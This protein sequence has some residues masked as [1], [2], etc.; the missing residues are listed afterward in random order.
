MA[1]QV[2]A[3]QLVPLPLKLKL[4]MI[5]TLQTHKEIP[6]TKS[7]LNQPTI[8]MTEIPEKHSLMILITLLV[9]M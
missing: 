2:I 1:A 9:M 3:F 4:L 5:Q 7:T 6:I 8:L